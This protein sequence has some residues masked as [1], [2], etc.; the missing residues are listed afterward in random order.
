MQKKSELVMEYLLNSDKEECKFFRALVAQLYYHKELKD[1][2]VETLIK[3]IRKQIMGLSEMH[4]KIDREAE[5]DDI[6]S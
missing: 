3:A 6:H 4:N 2:G 1:I 5:K